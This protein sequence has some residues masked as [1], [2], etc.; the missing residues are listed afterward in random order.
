MTSSLPEPRGG[1]LAVCCNPAD[2]RFLLVK[3]ANAPDAGLWGFPG[4]RIEPG[5]DLF[6]A[7]SRELAEETGIHARAASVLTALD[8][9]HHAPDGRL[10]FHY[11]IVAIRCVLPE[12]ATTI[13]PRANDD[14]LEAKWFTLDEIVQMAGR[15]SRGVLDLARLA[16]N[17]S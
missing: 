8:S 13:T 5:E 4:G 16:Q 12:D 11:V 15:S 7:A 2:G 3:R 9:I 14:A 10:L 6:T 1:V 17:A